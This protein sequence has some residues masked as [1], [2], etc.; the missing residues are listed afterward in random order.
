MYE[1]WKV[2][3]HRSRNGR[4]RTANK[5]V[6]QTGQPTR[7]K[8]SSYSCLFS[9]VVLERCRCC[10]SFYLTTC[11]EYCRNCRLFFRPKLFI[12]SRMLCFPCS[13]TSSSTVPNPGLTVPAPVF[14]S[15][16]ATLSGG[17]G[18]GLDSVFRR[19]PAFQA[20]LPPPLSPGL[21]SSSVPELLGVLLSLRP[22]DSFALVLVDRLALIPTLVSALVFS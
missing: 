5:V 21:P 6:R 22:P 15:I 3:N 8:R 20:L 2:E 14:T 19:G 1:I 11:S 7:S 16:V 18:G 10:D 4:R 17:R 9:T 13:L 12:P